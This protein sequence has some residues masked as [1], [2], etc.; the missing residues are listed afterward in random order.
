MSAEYETPEEA[1]QKP[2]ERVAFWLNELSLADK[3]EERWRKRATEVSDIYE[4]EK[5][6]QNS[7]N[8]LFS[9]TETLL[10]ALYNASPRPVVRRRFKDQD[11]VGLLAARAGTRILEFSLDTADPE[12]ASFDSC[13]QQAVVDASVPGRAVLWLSPGENCVHPEAVSWDQFRHSYGKRWEQVWW[14]ARYHDMTREELVDNFPDIGAKVP[15]QSAESA[16]ELKTRAK[17]GDN[18]GSLKVA[19]VWEI[20]SKRDKK[21]LWIA[22]AYPYGILREADDPYKLQGFYPHTQPLGFVQKVNNL[23]PSC[24]YEFYEEQAKE[25]NRIT[26]RINKIIGMMK[27]RGIY[28]STVEE[29]GKL[30]EQDD[31]K[32][33]PAEGLMGL[34]GGQGQA[35]L[36]KALWMQ[37]I[38]KLVAVLQQLYAQREQVKQVIYEITGIADILRGSSKA[39]ETLGAQQIKEK[40]G[41]LRI[42]RLQKLV[43]LFVRDNLR[44]ALEMAVQMLPQ[45]RLTAMTGMQVASGEDRAKA[46][47]AIQQLATAGQQPPPE[48][49]AAVQAPTWDDVFGLLRDDLQRSF[50]IDIETNS[51]VDV[52]ATEDHNMINEFMVAVGQFLNGVGPLIQQGILPF[53]AA[54]SMLLAVSR[55]YRF[56]DEVEDQI[57]QM[58]APPPPQDDGKAQVASQKAELDKAGM[59]L[60]KG[61]FA[62]E[63]MGE[64]MKFDLEKEQVTQE[65]ALDRANFQLDQARFQLEQSR[66]AFER[67]KFEFEKQVKGAELLLQ[68]AELD[69]ADEQAAASR[70][71]EV[72]LARQGQEAET[73]REERAFAA[74]GVAE[75]EKATEAVLL[76]LERQTEA[77]VGALTEIQQQIAETSTMLAGLQEE[78]RK[79]PSRKVEYGPDGKAVSVGGRPIVRRPDGKIIDLG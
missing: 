66:L 78:V 37:P 31:G 33:I 21:L 5:R 54:Q 63:M 4:A 77:I 42:R 22:T 28:D 11:A 50:R 73:A 45:D 32:M 13:F 14:T 56:G 57:M 12:Y 52:E 46:I 27:V 53:Q 1:G 17:E 20:W 29:L 8:I 15:V 71:H 67:E 9:N 79:P 51:T 76:L 62:V 64:K 55:R 43:Q 48:L 30:F 40:W 59:E 7:F 41:G 49:Q 36:E 70:D 72:G 16:E 19:R 61:K 44:L 39:S 34:S 60:D 3:R 47:A 74:K 65:L 26:I 38:E 24:P 18:H 35:V 2:D 25:L 68:G 58:K 10:P 23:K 75:G 69:Q 6:D